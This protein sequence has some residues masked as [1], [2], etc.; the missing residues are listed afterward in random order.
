MKRLHKEDEQDEQECR[1]QH[2]AHTVDDL[3]RIQREIVGCREENR[4]VEQL[5][6]RQIVLAEEGAYANLE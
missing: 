3:V 2:L 5:S 1:C 6:E 4:R